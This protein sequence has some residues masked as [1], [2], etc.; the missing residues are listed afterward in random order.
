MPQVAPVDESIQTRDVERG[1]GFQ[2][3]SASIDPPTDRNTTIQHWV[4]QLIEYTRM[5]L[6]IAGVVTLNHRVGSALAVFGL[7]GLK[8]L[9]AL[10]FA[11]WTARAEQWPKDTPYQYQAAF[12]EIG[13][14]IVM[15]VLLCINASDAALAACM[16]V[17]LI[18]LIPSGLHH[19]FV[20]MLNGQ[21]RGGIPISRI[22][23]F[24]SVGDFA[25]SAFG[26]LMIFAAWKPFKA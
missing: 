25:I 10:L 2:Q 20:E 15:L 4:V 13:V 6:G 1:G 16:L 17:V 21:D 11:R 8:G 7:F 5:G 23:Y 22:H 26:I 3:S 24:R 14:S 19:F 9:G 12:P 18:S